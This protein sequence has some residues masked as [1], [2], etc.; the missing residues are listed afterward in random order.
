MLSL[1]HVQIAID[2]LL[3]VTILLLLRKLGKSGSKNDIPI[4][5][6]L[7]FDLKKLVTD[8]Y[9]STNRFLEAVEGNKKALG[10]L[11]LQLDSKGKKLAGLVQ[12]AEAS[13]KKLDH[14]KAA[15]EEVSTEK[16][17]DDVI[18]MIHRGLS[19]EEVSK[20]LGFTEG[21]IDLIVDL[22]KTRNGSVP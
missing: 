2:L 12:E 4:N 19:R 18:R 15:S 21:E 3:F 7:V 1:L 6:A 16:K 20:Q 8:T 9:D 17:Y 11:L 10:T 13:I 14:A 5:E 22:A